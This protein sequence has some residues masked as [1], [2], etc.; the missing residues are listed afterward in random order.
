MA[1]WDTEKNELDPAAVKPYSHKA[2]WWRCSHGHS[3]QQMVYSVAAAARTGCPYCYGRI[4]I[5]GE[6]DLVTVMPELALEWDEEK[7]GEPATSVSPGSRKIVWW[8]CPEGHS[9]KARVYT[10]TCRNGSGCPYCAGKKPLAGYNDL[11]TA[12]PELAAEWDEEKNGMSPTEVMRKSHKK[13]WWRCEL[14]HSYESEIYARAV[15]NGCPYCAGRKVLAGFNDLATTHPK[16]AKQ[17]AYELNG[18]VT[19][20]MITKGSNK[21]FWWRCSEGHYWK[22]VVFSRT[23]KRAS[24]CPVCAGTVKQP[25]ESLRNAPTYRRSKAERVRATA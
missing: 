8:R 13:V 25:P 10:R 15:G 4:P 22:A 12:D 7:N 23:R 24:D 6:S 3:W 2:V 17:W 16:V 5:V 11:L 18:N 9:Y 14:G 1:L 19:P 20:E 21:K